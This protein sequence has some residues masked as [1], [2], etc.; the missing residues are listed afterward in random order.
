M[1]VRILGLMATFG[2]SMY[3]LGFILIDTDEE[4]YYQ[5]FAVTLSKAYQEIGCQQD[6][7]YC[8]E[9]S[10]EVVSV[11]AKQVAYE[12]YGFFNDARDPVNSYMRGFSTE[13]KQGA[14]DWLA[15]NLVNTSKRIYIRDDE[16]PIIKKT[17]EVKS[18][19]EAILPSLTLDMSL[20]T[21]ISLF[22]TGFLWAFKRL[23]FRNGTDV[24]ASAIESVA[25]VA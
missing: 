16:Y 2:I 10:S 9:A 12:F 5:D 15:S 23:I 4:I 1:F 7:I 24:V 22:V 3:L 18:K 8:S 11:Y 13:A 19:L 21:L 17:D 6:E 14:S 25:D 20:L